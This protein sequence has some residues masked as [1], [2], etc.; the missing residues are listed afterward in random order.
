M[1]SRQ[2]YYDEKDKIMG[3]DIVSQNL[4]KKTNY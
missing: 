2:V 3:L 4:P 1:H